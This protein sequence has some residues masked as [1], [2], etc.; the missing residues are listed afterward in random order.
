MKKKTKRII[1]ISAIGVLL[2]GGFVYSQSN[3]TV[4]EYSAILVEPVTFVQSVEETGVIDTQVSITYGWEQSGRVIAVA[5]EVG[6]M[7]SSTDIIARLDDRDE[8]N[9][10]RQSRAQYAAASA[11]LSEA[12]AGPTEENKQTYQARVAQA[13]AT[14]AQADTDLL[15]T[16][17][18]V[19]AT[20]ADAE[21]AVTLA[22]NTL[23]QSDTISQAV[24]DAYDDLVNTMESVLPNLRDALTESDNILRIDNQFA[25]EDL[26]ELLGVE[27]TGALTAA[28]AQYTKAKNAVRDAEDMVIG[29]SLTP[30]F[31]DVDFASNEVS[32]AVREINTLLQYVLDTLDA[33]PAV[34]ALSEG[35]LDLLKSGIITEK[36]SITADKS[37][38]TNAVQAVGSAKNSTESN[39]INLENAKAALETA[40][41]TGDQQVASA[42]RIVELRAAALSEAR[43]SYNSLVAPPRDVDVAALRADV[44]RYSAAVEAAQTQV[45]DMVLRALAD[46]TITM[47]DVSVG[48]TVSIGQDIVTIQSDDRKIEVDISESD[49]AKIA[50]DDTARIEL[51]AYDG[52]VL[53]ASVTKI[54]PAATEISGVV[55][56]KTTLAVDVPE[57][58]DV[59]PGMTADVQIITEE[60]ADSIAVPRR[61]V[62]TDADTTET[63]VRILTDADTAA[64]ERRPVMVGFSG[65]DGMVEILSGIELGETVVTFIEE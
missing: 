28:T 65:D 22:E 24:Q 54:D 4:P 15:N 33:T 12:L 59:R 19:A 26:D 7:V 25:N 44:S 58:L 16:R 3:Q 20:I 14:L 29:L 35:E 47:L 48:E 1:S 13:E 10:L 45:D 61:A 27:N 53:A 37:S 31:T 50:V 60:V 43:A 40:N 42:E 5:G 39:E 18:T 8:L 55:Y 36:T 6:A 34:G 51:D 30:A 63:Y 41:R 52:V 49:I 38:M 32:T 11:R 62:L 46:G 17:I 23:Q 57:E 21:R 9:A 56:Y 2:I 64:Y